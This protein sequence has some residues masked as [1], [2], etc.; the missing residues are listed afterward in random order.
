[1]KED[2]EVLLKAKKQPPPLP[3]V[4][5]GVHRTTG[6][7]SGRSKGRDGDRWV[8]AGSLFG[9]GPPVRRKT[10]HPSH[11]HPPIGPHRNSGPKAFPLM[12]PRAQPA[13]SL[14]S[15]LP[16]E[17]RGGGWGAGTSL[18]GIPLAFLGTMP[19]FLLASAWP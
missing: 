2:T 13:R 7:V 11:T 4:K 18:P 1:M 17:S 5:Q 12:L 6:P 10:C 3:L 14:S 16:A 8:C 19:S 9:D 15:L